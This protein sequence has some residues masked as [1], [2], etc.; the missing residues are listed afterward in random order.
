M[1]TDVALLGDSRS[2]ARYGWK[3]IRGL[4]SPAIADNG[5]DMPQGLENIGFQLAA[6]IEPHWISTEIRA[7]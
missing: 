6:V 5:S 2:Q 4:L 3:S 7:A 1:N